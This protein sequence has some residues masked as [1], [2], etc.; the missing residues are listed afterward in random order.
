M[1]RKA[2]G[3]TVAGECGCADALTRHRSSGRTPT[4]ETRGLTVGE[5]DQ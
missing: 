4:Q 1:V 2:S 5:T 3:T